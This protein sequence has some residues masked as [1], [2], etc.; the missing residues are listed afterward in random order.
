MIDREAL[1]DLLYDL[2]SDE[3]DLPFWEACARHEFMVYHCLVCGRSYW[4]AAMCV[5]HGNRNLGWVPASGRG[6]LHVPAV[7]RHAYLASMR[8][9]VPYNVSVIR[10]DEG[11]FFHA[12]VIDTPPEA[13]IGGT[14]VE[15]VFAAHPSG[16]TIPVFRRSAAA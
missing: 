16:L 7:M 8:D 2:D 1:R 10:L 15:A 3:I 6:T 9:R 5:V 4:P 14:P 13:L 11:P 12:T